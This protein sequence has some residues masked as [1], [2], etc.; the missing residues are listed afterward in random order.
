MANN[1][2]KFENHRQISLKPRVHE[3]LELFL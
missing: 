1:K 2:I 3:A